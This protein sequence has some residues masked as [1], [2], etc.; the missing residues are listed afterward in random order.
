MSAR[1]LLRRMNVERR[2]F[3]RN[4]DEWTWR[5]RAARKY[6][7]IAREVPACDWPE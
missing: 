7:W 3:P 6:A 4:S 5:T 1:R 2:R